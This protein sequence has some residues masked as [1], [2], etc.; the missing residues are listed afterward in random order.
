MNFL[1]ILAYAVACL[2]ILELYIEVNKYNKTVF[3][4]PYGIGKLKQKVAQLDADPTREQQGLLRKCNTCSSSNQHC[5]GVTGHTL[6]IR[7]T[8][9]NPKTCLEALT[10]DP[11]LE[12]GMFWIDP[13]GQGSGDGPIYVYCNMTTGNSALLN[14]YA[15]VIKYLFSLPGST[16]VLHDSEDAIDIDHCFDPGCYS[17]PIKYNAT[18]R[19]MTVLSEISDVCQQSIQV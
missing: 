18:L 1:H 14:L 8:A 7:N 4:F 5:N 6:G 12:S 19:Q 15:H 16:S 3:L 10:A 2:V 17:R 11:S 13:D 9:G